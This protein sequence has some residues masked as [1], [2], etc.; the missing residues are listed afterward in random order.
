MN[1][2]EKAGGAAACHHWIITRQ[3]Y[4]GAGLAPT[5]GGGRLG[6][7]L[8]GGAVECSAGRL[9]RRLRLG[10]GRA[11]EGGRR[12]GRV[13]F[14]AVV[15]RGVGRAAGLVARP[16]APVAA[17]PHGARGPAAATPAPAEV[18]PEVAALRWSAA[19]P[20][21]IPLCTPLVGRGSTPS[22][23][24]PAWSALTATSGA[25]TGIVSVKQLT[26]FIT[27]QIADRHKVLVLVYGHHVLI[28]L[29]GKDSEQESRL[30]FPHGYIGTLN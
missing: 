22:Y 21:L 10:L 29:K 15:A 16:H 12:R 17:A 7:A 11:L 13:A 20:Y 23:P 3:N 4:R 1:R 8:V 24:P 19:L 27:R 9:G 25:L 18:A 26:R 28:L 14:L 30:A 6:L 2:R 5:P